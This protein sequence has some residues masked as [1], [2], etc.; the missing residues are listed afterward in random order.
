MKEVDKVSVYH[1][2]K[3]VGT[4]IIL[5]NYFLYAVLLVVQDLKSLQ[6]LMEKIGL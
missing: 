1:N 4:M 2:G 6:R 3:I 5:M